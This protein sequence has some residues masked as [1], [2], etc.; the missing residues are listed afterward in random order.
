MLSIRKGIG[1]KGDFFSERKVAFL[2][3]GE[4]RSFLRR[5]IFHHLLGKEVSLQ[6][7][8][9]PHTQRRGSNLS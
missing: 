9:H 6:K 3:Q 7:L 1:R 8:A 4:E 5:E 2:R